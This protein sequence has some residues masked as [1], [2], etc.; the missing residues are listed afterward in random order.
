MPPDWGL[1]P[2]DEVGDRMPGEMVELQEGPQ[3]G[4][5]T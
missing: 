4:G 5:E 2:E 1:R 3:E